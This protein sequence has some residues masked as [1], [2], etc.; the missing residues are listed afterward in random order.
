MPFGLAVLAAVVALV[1]NLRGG[2]RRPL[3]VVGLVLSGTALTAILYGAE[4]ASQ[5][6]DNAWQ[7]TGLVV[8]GAFVALR[9][10]R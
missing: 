8:A 1:P 7:A 10:V 6:G 5:P 3:D 2:E 4:L 9:F